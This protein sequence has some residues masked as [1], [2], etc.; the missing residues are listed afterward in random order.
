MRALVL[1]FADE[2]EKLSEPS[3]IPQGMSRAQEA[4]LGL[5][6]D[7]HQQVGGM[8]PVAAMQ[9]SQI[10]RFKREVSRHPLMSWLARA[11]RTGEVGRTS[12]EPWKTSG[13]APMERVLSL[14][15]PMN[16]E[17]AALRRLAPRQ[18]LLPRVT[19]ILGDRR[20]ARSALRA[21]LRR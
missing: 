1:G 10:G 18:P 17:Q 13:T 4:S 21:A 16:E 20:A 2:L 5:A 6:R 3:R 12:G 19:G 9:E 8:A 7:L 11:L 15:E 14:A